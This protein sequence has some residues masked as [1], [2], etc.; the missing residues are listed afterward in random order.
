MK[1]IAYYISDFGFGHASRSIAVIR[2]L[3]N[4][5]EAEIM[6]CHSFALS[7]Y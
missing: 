2:K 1:T 4:H 5:P 6:I 7:F 3:L